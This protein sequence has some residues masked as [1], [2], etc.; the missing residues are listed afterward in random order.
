MK[1]VKITFIH[2]SHDQ[3]KHFSPFSAILAKIAPPIIPDT[4]TLSTLANA[5][6]TVHIL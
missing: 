3:N 1:V 4:I 5:V 6:N 2:A